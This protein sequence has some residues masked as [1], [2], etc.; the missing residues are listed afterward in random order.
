MM[1]NWSIDR[2]KIN[3]FYELPKVD[4]ETWSLAR[5]SLYTSKPIVRTAKM[6]SEDVFIFT[7]DGYKNLIDLKVIQGKFTQITHD[8]DSFVDRVI[9]VKTICLNKSK[10]SDSICS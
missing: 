6:N 8:F 2:T 10:W 4:G 1:R 3:V 5:N 9:R 7:R